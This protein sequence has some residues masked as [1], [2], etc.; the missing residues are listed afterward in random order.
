MAEGSTV[1][2]II[3][4]EGKVKETVKMEGVVEGMRMAEGTIR[5]K[6]MIMVEETMEGTIKVEELWNKYK[7][8]V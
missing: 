6:G 2:D 4:F 1:G 5:F 7:W 3:T 8:G